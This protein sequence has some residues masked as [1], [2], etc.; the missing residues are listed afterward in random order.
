MPFTTLS[1]EEEK[2]LWR[3][4]RFYWQE[5]LRCER[6]KAYLAGCVTLGSALE[7]LLILMIN[8]FSDE[9]DQTGKIPRNKDKLKPLLDWQLVELLADFVIDEIGRARFECPDAVLMF[10]KQIPVVHKCCSVP[11]IFDNPWAVHAYAYVHLLERYR[12][13]WTVLKYLSSVA[14]L[15]LG[16]R[17]VRTLD[18]GTGPAPALFAIPIFIRL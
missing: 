18:I 17:G 11:G 13:T 9:A 7:T 12:R 3:L 8:C 16:V 2:E 6:G 1:S 5:A 14:V 15:P 10:W 4:S